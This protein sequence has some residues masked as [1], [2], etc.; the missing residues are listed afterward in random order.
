MT[1][2]DLEIGTH[3]DTN[4]NRKISSDLE[5]SVSAVLMRLPA[6]DNQQE[7]TASGRRAV[8]DG[9]DTENED[10]PYRYAAECAYFEHQSIADQVVY[11]Y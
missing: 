10:N 3:I 7:F 9:S 8:S 4:T 5:R 2:S 1:T 6:M 11:G